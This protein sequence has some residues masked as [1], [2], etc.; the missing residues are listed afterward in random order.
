[1]DAASK[2]LILMIAVAIIAG[3]IISFVKK[4]HTVEQI[5]QTNENYYPSVTKK[6]ISR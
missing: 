3:A 1:M 2:I 4:D 6:S 5:Y